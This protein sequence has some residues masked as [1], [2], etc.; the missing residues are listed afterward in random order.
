MQIYSKGLRKDDS[1]L[2]YYKKDKIIWNHKSQKN[3]GSLGFTSIK[4][5]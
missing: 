3:Q 4:D 1:I 2:V 5:A